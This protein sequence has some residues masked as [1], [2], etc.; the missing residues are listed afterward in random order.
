MDCAIDDDRNIVVAMM[1]FA[2][3]PNLI[4]HIRPQFWS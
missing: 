4:L 3:P 1:D 2:F